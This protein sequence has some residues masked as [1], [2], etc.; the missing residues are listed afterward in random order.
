MGE[1]ARCLKYIWPFYN[2]MHERV[3]DNQKIIKVKGKYQK[4]KKI[5]KFPDFCL[6]G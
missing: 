2:I 6:C 4:Y 1:H 5:S 3:E